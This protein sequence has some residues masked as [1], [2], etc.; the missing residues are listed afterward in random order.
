MIIIKKT[1]PAT[2]KDMEK[3]EPS[4]IADGYIQCCHFGKQ[5]GSF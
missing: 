3:P 4:Y 5:F 2:G 1:V